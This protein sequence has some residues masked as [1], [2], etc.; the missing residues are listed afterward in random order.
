L[1]L[2]VAIVAK[3]A[4]TIGGGAV[5]LERVAWRPGDRQVRGVGRGLEVASFGHLT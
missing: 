4:N 5:G 2:D 1:W 3:G